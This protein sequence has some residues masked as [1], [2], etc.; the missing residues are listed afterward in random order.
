LV[1]G[2]AKG[3][4]FPLRGEEEKRGKGKIGGGKK[5]RDASIYGFKGKGHFEVGE[6]SSFGKTSKI[7][8]GEREEGTNIREELTWRKGKGQ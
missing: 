4:P 1:R 6:R 5:E 8:E 7:R 2:D 3:R